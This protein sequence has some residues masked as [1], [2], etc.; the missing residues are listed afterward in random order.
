MLVHHSNVKALLPVRSSNEEAVLQGF[1][2]K[3]GLDSPSMGLTDH[4][5]S[6]LSLCLCSVA[7][8]CQTLYNPMD[9]SLPGSSVRAVF[10]ARILEWVAVSH[11]RGFSWPR[12]WTCVSCIGRQILYHWATWEAPLLPLILLVIISTR[13][14]SQPLPEEDGY[15]D[16]SSLFSAQTFL[17][18]YLD[19]LWKHLSKSKR[20]H[21]LSL[22]DL[23]PPQSLPEFRPSTVGS[24]FFLHYHP[25][26]APSISLLLYAPPPPTCCSILA[27]WFHNRWDLCFPRHP[28]LL[29]G[30]L[31]GILWLPGTCTLP[32]PSPGSEVTHIEWAHKASWATWMPNQD[33]NWAAERWFMAKGSVRMKL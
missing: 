1:I 30:A 3:L 4:S 19:I 26:P 2:L 18:L 12:D 28:P 14:W 31:P 16:S 22:W 5:L 23:P 13:P 7:Q 6:Q 8:S 33:P 11:S 10:H 24:Y 9:Y 17:D 25:T 27:P 32:S 29:L 15:D 20:P 21:H